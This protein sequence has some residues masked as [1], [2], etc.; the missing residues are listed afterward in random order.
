[1]T[2]VELLRSGGT[3]AVPAA[4]DAARLVSRALARGRFGSFL[5]EAAPRGPI[6]LVVND[7]HRAVMPETVLRG[8]LAVAAAEGV[9]ER[10]RLLVA[11]GSHRFSAAE[12]ARHERRVLRASARRVPEREWHDQGREELLAAAGPFRFHRWLLGG[13]ACVAVGTTEPHYFA[14][15]TGAHKSLTVGLM[16]AEDLR[17]NHESALDP[18]AAP[19][20]IDGNPVFEK[21]GWALEALRRAGARLFAVNLLAAGSGLAAC[22]AGPPLEALRRILPEVRRR[23]EVLVPAALD[24]IVARVRPPLD[25][26]FYQADKGI[27]NVEGAVR[28]G[29]VIILDAACA[30]GIGIDAF[31]EPLRRARGLAGTLALIERNGYRL[32]DH[33]A[34]RLRWLTG[35]RR[36]RVGVISRA[37]TRE[38][39]RLLGV[40]RLRDRRTATSWALENLPR[41]RAPRGL[42]LEDAGNRVVSLRRM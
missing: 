27:K 17:A 19:L 38:T 9:R 36:V 7:P 20:V 10:W 13:G 6:T 29:G 8:L 31:L 40:A 1:M 41:G 15:V 42:I 24:L 2:G 34:V 37:L 28:D 11:T 25:R 39:A 33:K 4:R 23:Q 3:L 18:R 16:S 21:I 12:R 30:G 32:G 22:A 14:G 35:R 26:T 5:R